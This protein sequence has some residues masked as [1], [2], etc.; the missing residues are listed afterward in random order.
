VQRRTFLRN[1]GA[2]ASVAAFTGQG[3]AYGPSLQNINL[4]FHGPFAFIIDDSIPGLRVLTPENHDHAFTWYDGKSYYK[5]KGAYELRGT[6]NRGTKPQPDGQKAI[7]I[8]AGQCGFKVKD[9]GTGP[10]YCS[11]ALPYPTSAPL[12][13]R[14]VTGDDATNVH[15]YGKYADT[16]KAKQ[17]P[18]VYV[19]NYSIK[20]KPESVVLYTDDSDYKPWYP[21]VSASYAN[22]HIF[23]EPPCG[24]DD[25]HAPGAFTAL[26]GLIHEK[27][28]DLF[29]RIYPTIYTPGPAGT[30]QVTDDETKSLEERCDEMGVCPSQPASGG[31]QI[32]NC[33]SAFITD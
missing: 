24:V 31:V 20:Q 22:L 1:M 5:M 7:V 19:F 6:F 10:G 32:V 23:A 15:F 17:F 18:L 13:L 29:C 3:N 9:A 28:A 25:A 27:V 2:L 12:L 8:S 16:I 33:M 4:V 26:V 14:N 21:D 11:F 30:G